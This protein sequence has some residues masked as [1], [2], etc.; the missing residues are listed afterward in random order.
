VNRLRPFLQEIISPGQSAFFL[1]RMITDNALIAFERLHAISTNSDDRGNFC[2][3]KLDLSKAYDR[4]DWG[5]LKKILLKLGDEI[6]T[7][8]Y[9]KPRNLW[10]PTEETLGRSPQEHPGPRGLYP[11]G[12][13]TR[14]LKLRNLPEPEHSKASAQGSGACPSLRLP[15]D[16]KPE[17]DPGLLLDRRHQ[18]GTGH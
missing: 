8:R 9:I 16:G 11:S 17:P 1:G 14:T 18:P 5:F 2:A 10:F 12:T 4:V 3:Y 6:L 13:L 7:Y 15:I